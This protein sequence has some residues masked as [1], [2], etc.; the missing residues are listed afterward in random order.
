MLLK[1]PAVEPERTEER[2]G[3]ADG[4]GALPRVQEDMD[5]CEN[6]QAEEFSRGTRHPVSGIQFHRVPCVFC[7]QDFNIE[8]QLDLDAYCF[9]DLHFCSCY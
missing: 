3:A 6:S 1:E 2:D 7:F 9:A 8:W 5:T 4:D